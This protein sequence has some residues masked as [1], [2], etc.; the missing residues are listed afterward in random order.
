M[1]M[2]IELCV[3]SFI[4]I[5]GFILFDQISC[6]VRNYCV[7]MGSLVFLKMHWTYDD[8]TLSFIKYSCDFLV[9]TYSM[10]YIFCD[11]VLLIFGNMLMNLDV[12]V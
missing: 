1:L 7:T 9:Y 11:L 8:W 3:F 4:L 10:W 12:F 5:L 2:Y 6:F